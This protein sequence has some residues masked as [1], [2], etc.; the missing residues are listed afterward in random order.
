MKEWGI[1]AAEA[2]V[3]IKVAL[4]GCPHA[5]ADTVVLCTGELVACICITCLDKLPAHWIS[6]QREHAETVA[7]CTHEDLIELRDLGQLHPD[8]TCNRCGAWNP[9]T[10][11]QNGYLS[12]VPFSMQE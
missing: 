2:A 4:G 3:N 9:N 6:R 10:P 7:R 5:Q 12:S 8:Y 1:S 11:I